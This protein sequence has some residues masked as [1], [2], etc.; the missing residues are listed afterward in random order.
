M[1]VFTA[2]DLKDYSCDVRYFVTN[3]R[4]LK[5]GTKGSGVVIYPEGSIY[6]G[7][8]VKVG[9]SFEK[10]G[11]GVQDFTNS[12]LRLGDIGTP[13]GYN[14]SLYVGM[15]DYRKSDWIYGNGVMYFVDDEGKPKAF[16]KGFF[17]AL[18]LIGDYRGEFDEKLL[19]P[20]YTMDMEYKGPFIRHQKL[21]NKLKKDVQQH[22][23]CD[24]LFFGDSYFENW[25]NMKFNPDDTESIFIKQA[26]HLGNVLNTGIGGYT[27][28]EFWP[29]L[30]DL[31]T[32]AKPKNIIINLGYNDIHRNWT[33][34]SIYS[35]FLR[36]IKFIHKRLPNTKIN[37]IGVTPTPA[38]ANYFELE[39]K[40]SALEK[41][42]CLQNK[43][44]L[45]YI[46]SEKVYMKDGKM[47]E[48]AADYLMPDL[49]HPNPA[50]YL[51]WA[52]DF[53]NKAKEFAEKE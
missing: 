19:L 16:T 7:Q 9:N 1:K 45:N 12:T 38:K 51:I 6:R 33:V 10:I 5:E 2:K 39:R 3:S 53:I 41:E 42:Y 18:E 44:Y 35:Y 46:D 37:V 50:G 21:I 32:D 36:T 4:V 22:I 14:L 28:R 34:S 23:G 25:T 43:E 13:E 49:V 24:Y 15:Y 11:Y 26:K 29:L 30:K 27:Y 48:D 17:S 47:R 40:L 8:L 52:T 20:G 31:V